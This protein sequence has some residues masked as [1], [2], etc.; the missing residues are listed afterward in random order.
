MKKNYL[1]VLLLFC[2]STGSFA[3][4][5]TFAD[6][7]FKARLLLASP[8]NQIARN[9]TGAYFK[10]DANNNSEIE[11]GE[12]AQVRYLNIG[13]SAWPAIS[14]VSGIENFVNLRTLHCNGNNLTELPLATFPL[15]DE[16]NCSGNSITALD[17]SN[18]P[19][20]K[21]LMFS[22][23]LVT[24]VNLSNLTQLE[25]LYASS[26][27]LAALN[28][29]GLSLLEQI[30]VPYN[31][32][33]SID[34][35][36]QPSLT[37][38]VC[39][40]NSLFG[41]DVSD[42]PDLL[43]L[44]CENNPITS[45]NLSGAVNLQQL[46]CH[47]TAI[48]HL[49]VTGF[50]NLTQ[51]DCQTGSLQSLKMKGIGY[52]PGVSNHTLGLNYTFSLEFICVSEN[53]L[54]IVTEMTA[55]PSVG[56]CLTIVTD[57]PDIPGIDIPDANLKAKLLSAACDTQVAGLN[58]GF[59]RIDTNLDGEIQPLEAQQPD[60]LYLEN[61]E[62]ASLQGLGA[63]TNLEKLNCQNNMI[64]IIDMTQLAN[65]TEIACDNNLLTS[66]DLSPAPGLLAVYCR[67]NEIADLNTNALGSLTALYCSNNQIP[68]I[69]FDQTPSL[70]FLDCANNQLTALDVS[71]VPTLFD[72]NCSYNQLSEINIS[73]LT[74]I[75]YLSFAGNT[76]ET[77][78]ISAL[79]DLHLIDASGNPIHEIDISAN[80]LLLHIEF[81]LTPITTIDAGHLT[82]LESINCS[83]CSA[84][85]SVYI[86]NGVYES[87]NFYGSTALQYICSDEVQVEE[88][89]T[90]YAEGLA[91][92]VINSYCSF[93]PGGEFYSIVGSVTVDAYNDGCDATDTNVGNAN[94]LITDG[95]TTGNF[96][97]NDTGNSVIAV[98]AGTHT[99]TPVL[100]NPEYFTITPENFAVEFPTAQNPTNFSFCMTPNGEH[101]DL[102]AVLVP[103]DAA[104]PGFDAHY[105]IIVRNKGNQTQDAVVNLAFNGS[106]SEFI[107]ADVS[108]TLQTDGNLSW[109]FT[110][111]EPMEKRVVAVVLNV[112]AP[113][114]TPAINGGDV[115]DYTLA[116]E[117][118]VDEMPADNTFV[119]NQTVVNSFDPNEKI[120]LEGTTVGS[121][122]I[123]EFVHYI[124]RFENTGTFPAENVV[125]K[126]MIDL[127]KFD[128]STLVPLSGSHLFE[129]RVSGNKVEFIFQNIMLPFD[130]ANN[131]GFLAFKIKTLP[132]LTVGDTFSNSASIYF[133]YNFPI[134]TDPA[135][136][137]IQSLANDDF[138]FSKYFTVY[139]I[140]TEN[141]LNVKASSNVQLKSF[142]VFNVLGQL[143]LAIPNAEAVSSLDVSP[144]KAGTYFLKIN[145]D[146]GTATAKFVKR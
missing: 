21:I 5:I 139:P 24:A 73:G 128:V 26:N 119:L 53:L 141:F 32:L 112:N 34:L 40:N 126:D 41:L 6:P 123:G 102:E 31:Q 116:V 105:E 104:R 43:Y 39:S 18:N 90:L 78:D 122:M 94:F 20:L 64:E 66:L 120:C 19:Q 30:F 49:D 13:Q 36:D 82:Q 129:T 106:V 86:K 8:S 25:V 69:D 55:I 124:I 7:E 15:L 79:T 60:L 74:E 97:A 140:P 1:F 42:K 125:V 136:T 11:V 101:S 9:L 72:M 93:T 117:N 61:S 115:L 83:D 109:S 12:A 2:V 50:S 143:V 134:V 108:P 135:V 85:Q 91:N 23:N 35:S 145:S 92:V 44:Q 33:T 75:M 103:V 16:L 37:S 81:S 14:S 133:D 144:L 38:L 77:V 29:S 70:V 110:A 127:S 71:M 95:S 17:F 57:C 111:L 27:Q 121:E 10:I 137:S 142:K 114:D 100:E 63:F 45:L 4:A 65:L 113:T 56:N 22:S 146:K 138:E 67:G 99:I 80:P 51:L 48:T 54:D 28:L 84:L 47:G 131:D 88:L 89:Q 3:Q 62:I 87:A 118:A 98:G 58:G 132:T 68:A 46:I 59:I 52:Q 130:N 107:S 96:L 76:I